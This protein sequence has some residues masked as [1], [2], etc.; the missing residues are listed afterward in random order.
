MSYWTSFLML[1]LHNLSSRMTKLCYMNKQFQINGEKHFV[2]FHWQQVN[3][4][5][6]QYRYLNKT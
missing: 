1:I 5:H 3:T 4:K 2:N 6:L